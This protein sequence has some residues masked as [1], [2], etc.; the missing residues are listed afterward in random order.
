MYIHRYACM[1]ISLQAWYVVTFCTHEKQ[2]TDVNIRNV[3]QKDGNL[4]H[5]RDFG[6]HVETSAVGIL[7]WK[8]CLSRV[9]GISLSTCC[10]VGLCLCACRMPD[11]LVAAVKQ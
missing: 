4:E 11:T 9:E 5:G 3:C 1:C 2:L 6:K 10:F 8:V 7:D